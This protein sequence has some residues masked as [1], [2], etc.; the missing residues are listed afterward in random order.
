MAGESEKFR[1]ASFYEALVECNS[2]FIERERLLSESHLR[3][4]EEERTR[5]HLLSPEP[6]NSVSEERLREVEDRIRGNIDALDYLRGISGLERPFTDLVTEIF[7]AALVLGQEDNVSHPERIFDSSMNEKVDRCWNYIRQLTDAVQWHVSQAVRYHK[8]HHETKTAQLQVQQ[9]SKEFANTTKDFELSDIL[10]MDQL[11]SIDGLLE[12]QIKK[13]NELANTARQLSLQS[14]EVAPLQYRNLIPSGQHSAQMLASMRLTDGTWI[15]RGQQVRVWANSRSASELRHE[16]QAETLDGKHSLTMPSVCLWLTSPEPTPQ[17]SLR[18]S[19]SEVIQGLKSQMHG[20]GSGLEKNSLLGNRASAASLQQDIL[21]MWMDM[22]NEYGH[23]LLPTYN[24]YLQSFVEQQADLSVPDVDLMNKLLETVKPLMD[25]GGETEAKILEQ[26]QGRPIRQTNKSSIVTVQELRQLLRTL[27]RW[28]ELR[29][30][31]RN[32]KRAASLRSVHKELSIEDRPATLRAPLQTVDANVAFLGSST[33]GHLQTPKSGGSEELV[34]SFADPAPKTYRLLQGELSQRLESPEQDETHTSRTTP[35]V[36]EHSERVKRTR[37]QPTWFADDMRDLMTQI[38]TPCIPTVV[39]CPN[40][41]LPY[42]IDVFSPTMAF[43]SVPSKEQPTSDILE[44]TEH[45]LPISSEPSLTAQTSASFPTEIRPDQ[46]MTSV[47]TQSKGR[48][49]LFRLPYRR[50]Q[51]CTTSTTEITDTSG[52]CGT[53]EPILTKNK[54]KS[55]KKQVS[56]GRPPVEEPRKRSRTPFFRW[57][58]RSQPTTPEALERTPTEQVE[59]RRA[60]SELGQTHPPRNDKETFVPIKPVLRSRSWVQHGTPWGYGPPL[61][62][63]WRPLSAKFSP[64]D[65]NLARLPRFQSHSDRIVAR[66]CRP[67]LITTPSDR[68]IWNAVDSGIQTDTDL[69]GLLS[70]T[71]MACRSPTTSA[72]ITA[73][74]DTC[75]QCL[76]GQTST[77]FYTVSAHALQMSTIPT[78]ISQKRIELLHEAQTQPLIKSPVSVGSQKDYSGFI[79]KTRVESWDVSCQVGVRMKDQGV[80]SDCRQLS[81]Q[82]EIDDIR[83]M[84]SQGTEITRVPQVDVTCQVGRVLVDMGTGP[85]VLEA[86]QLLDDNICSFELETKANGE[87]KMTVIQTPT[88]A[89]VPSKAMIGKKLQVGTP[90]WQDRTPIGSSNLLNRATSPID[91][92]MLEDFDD[93]GLY[94]NLQPC[95][96]QSKE[97][98]VQTAVSGEIKP[99]VPWRQVETQTD[100]TLKDLVTKG[101]TNGIPVVETPSMPSIVRKRVEAINQRQFNTSTQIGRKLASKEQQT[102]IDLKMLLPLK[103]STISMGTEANIQPDKTEVDVQTKVL[104]K[105]STSTQIG[106]TATCHPNLKRTTDTSIGHIVAEKPPGRIEYTAVRSTPINIFSISKELQP[107]TESSSQPQ[108]VAVC[109]N[110]ENAPPATR[111]KRIQKGSPTFQQQDQ[112]STSELEILDDDT[113]SNELANEI[114]HR[115]KRSLSKHT[116]HHVVVDIGLHTN[117]RGKYLDRGGRQHPRGISQPIRIEHL[118]EKDMGETTTETYSSSTEQETLSES[119]N[120]FK[121]RF[122]VSPR[123]AIRSG[124]PQ[125]RHKHLPRRHRSWSA[126][127]MNGGHGKSSRHFETKVYKTYV[128]ETEESHIPSVRSVGFE[129]KTSVV[130]KP[131]EHLRK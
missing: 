49:K 103:P 110:R 34:T 30:H 90:W 39:H 125:H 86:V 116:Q 96:F 91:A 87:A 81:G 45:T 82:F 42:E 83:G 9:L 105:S 36:F 21:N 3:D 7:R 131:T 14:R 71:I 85:D 60:L 99:Q 92:Q 16:W 84:R 23:I 53:P 68:S 43:N 5:A 11:A 6:V 66:A 64:E 12:E 97:K 44:S 118:T 46:S 88:T 28:G 2:T 78:V 100:Q 47:K 1:T 104:Q 129:P 26:L 29:E 102:E 54:R 98:C 77:P 106:D 75:R 128:V 4:F 80:L 19:P 74:T 32:A 38:T 70:D 113:V 127:D 58:K 108:E 65:S 117:T 25:Y 122:Y 126:D 67:R 50:S 52:V 79:D 111:C 20:A 72:T 22:I 37:S 93:Q 61:H 59:P 76:H 8:F 31:L 69:A 121:M 24:K 13:L 130:K 124:R 101:S 18:G 17:S 95:G 40:C 107:P 51:S 119:V 62:D 114:S 112:E 48:R 35:I 15:H 63:S 27:N 123:G 120:S 10:N 55:R 33:T 94:E 41:A 115:Q 57:G 109:A 89:S 73:P 56:S